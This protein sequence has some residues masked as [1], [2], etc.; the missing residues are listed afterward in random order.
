MRAWCGA[1]NVPQGF[2]QVAEWLKAYAW[3]AYLGETLTRVRIPLCPPPL[4]V[5]FLLQCVSG[6]SPGRAGPLMRH[7][8]KQELDY[9]TGTWDQYFLYLIFTKLYPANA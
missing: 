8:G 9:L 4:F 6:R 3:K 7:L 2:G 5:Y 1:P